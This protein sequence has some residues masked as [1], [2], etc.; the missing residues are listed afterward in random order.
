MAYESPKL[1]PEVFEAR[2]DL[3]VQLT[4]RYIELS[5]EVYR[6]EI[7]DSPITHRLGLVDFDLLRF[8]GLCVYVLRQSRNMD[9]RPSHLFLAQLE[10]V[11]VTWARFSPMYDEM[12]AER[13]RNVADTDSWVAEFGPEI[14]PALE[15][16]RLPGYCSSRLVILQD[17]T[18]QRIVRGIVQHRSGR[19]MEGLSSGAGSSVATPSIPNA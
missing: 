11:S 10:V 6:P 17:A 1:T 13:L 5:R 19:A 18:V 3:C 14:L 8:L 16:E 15:R 4:H 2:G 12:R 9:H 7:R